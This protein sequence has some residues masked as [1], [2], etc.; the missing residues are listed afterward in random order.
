MKYYGDLSTHLGIHRITGLR[1]LIGDNYLWH[2][3]KERPKIVA[4][5]AISSFIIAEIVLEDSQEISLIGEV[6]S[7]R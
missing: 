6:Q 1:T 7:L 3:G 5:F 4:Q 2:F